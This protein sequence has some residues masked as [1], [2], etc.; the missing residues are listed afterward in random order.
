MK[1]CL[2]FRHTWEKKMVVAG[3]RERV[4]CSV[5][6][7]R[8]KERPAHSWAPWVTGQHSYFYSRGGVRIKGSDFVKAVQRRDC[9][10]C[11]F[12]EERLI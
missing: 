4:D 5:C 2:P 10:R 8:G 11:N 3:C 9:V 1:F 6:G 7:K 12:T